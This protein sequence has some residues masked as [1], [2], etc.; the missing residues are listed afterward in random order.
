MKRVRQFS[1]RGAETGVYGKSECGY[2]L[3]FI[4]VGSGEKSVIITAVMH[5]REWVGALAALENAESAIEH[6]LGTVY[7][8]PVV[9]PDGL[10]LIEKGADAFSE[11]K[12]FLLDVNGGSDDFS[13]WKANARAVDLNVNFDAGWG[14]GRFNVFTP[15]P[16]NFVGECAF[17]EAETRALR[18]FTLAV[19]PSMTVSYHA[20]GR[21]V[22]WRFHQKAEA[23]GRDEKIA[24]AVAKHL[25]YEPVKTE[26]GSAG[27]Y[28]DWCVRALNIPALTIELVA[29]NFSHPLSLASAL[30]DVRR[31]KDLPGLLFRLL[32]E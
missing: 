25:G 15:S 3:P 32:Q 26:C 16:E 20:K 18:D 4:K 11:R 6:G 14:S 19:K 23:V 10:V 28:K 8:L 13:L 5:A 7:V 29:D 2:E 31:A 12:K 24:S 9:N 30:E 27:G 17:S 22:Y 1:L 21:E